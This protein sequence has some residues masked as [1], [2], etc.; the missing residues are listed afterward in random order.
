MIYCYGF[1]LDSGDSI[2]T[3]S[4]RQLDMKKR[5]L[6]LGLVLFGIISFVTLLNAHSVS[7]NAPVSVVL[8][9]NTAAQSLDVTITHGPPSGGHYIDFIEIKKNSVINMTPTYTSQPSYTYTVSFSI[10]AQEGD[11]LSAR[12]HCVLGFELTGTLTVPSTSGGNPIIPPTGIPGITV[13]QILF[14]TFIVLMGSVWV[15][16]KKTNLIR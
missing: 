9:Y 3:R 10:A 15:R 5:C 8:S 2:K 1:M 13:F 6:Q 16:R 12:A 4:Y 11:V 7:A 14:W